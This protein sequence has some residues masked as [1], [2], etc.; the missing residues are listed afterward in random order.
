MADQVHPKLKFHWESQRPLA[1]G[2]GS[3]SAF[4]MPFE[5]Q[6]PVGAAPST[7][8]VFEALIQ[9][10]LSSGPMN[11][12]R[13]CRLAQYAAQLGLSAVLAG[14]Y[15]SKFHARTTSRRNP[16]SPL[17]MTQTPDDTQG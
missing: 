2:E 13:R 11:R 14:D 8:E 16:D 10:E 9:W 7:R 3:N 12:S 6:P 4:H 1:A 15:I 17:R 5:P